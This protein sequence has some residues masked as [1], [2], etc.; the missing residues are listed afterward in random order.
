LPVAT[1]PLWHVAQGRPT[2]CAW[3]KRA[4]RQAPVW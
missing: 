1:L 3:S 4:G 2:A